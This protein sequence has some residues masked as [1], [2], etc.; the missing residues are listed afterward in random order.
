MIH[1]IGGCRFS[2]F[3]VELQGFVLSM[4]L[5]IGNWWAGC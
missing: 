2:E 1:G 4:L 3:E 5:W